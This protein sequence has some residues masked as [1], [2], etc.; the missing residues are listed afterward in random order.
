MTTAAKPGYL[1]VLAVST[2]GGSTYNPIGELTDM[3]VT[4]TT[5]MLDATSH[6]S[7]G[8]EEYVP[9]NTGWTATAKA[10]AVYSDTAQSAIQA[11][12][13]PKTKLKFRI[14]PVGTTV[15]LPRRV[16]DG[17]IESWKEAEPASN[18]VA[19]DLSIRGTG[20]LVFSTQ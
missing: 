4:I 16:G 18:L 6:S 17:F 3:D 8:A 10:L 15:G 11:A 20:P 19:V 13:T 7:G 14:D 12:L 9:G 1:G 2:D 5:K